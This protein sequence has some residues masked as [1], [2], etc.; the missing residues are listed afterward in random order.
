MVNAGNIVIHYSHFI[1]SQ[2]EEMTQQRILQFLGLVMIFTLLITAIGSPAA[3]SAQDVAPNPA[4]DGPTP[5][6]T[7]GTPEPSMAYPT[8]FTAYDSGWVPINP[9]QTLTLNHN[10][11]GSTDNYIVDLSFYSDNSGIEDHGI[12][13][14]MYGGNEFIAPAPSGY[15][16]GDNVGAFWHSLTTTHIKVYRMPQD[17]SYA[18]KIRVRIWVDSAED[19]DSGWH[20]ITPGGNY[21]FSFT[22]PDG[23]ADNYLVDLQ[24]RDEGTYFPPASSFGVHQRYYGG[25]SLSNND[26]VGAY[27]RTLTNSSVIV[28]LRPNETRIDSVRVRIWNNP[29]ATYDSGWQ[30]TTAGY[31]TY[32]THNI[33]GNPQDY[34]VDLEYKD[35]GT[36]GISNRCFGGC[37]LGDNDGIYSNTKEGAYWRN[38]TKSSI[39]V[40]RRADDEFAVHVRIR[41]WHFWKPSRPNFDSGWRTTTPG[42]ITNLYHGL[43]GD[44]NDYLVYFI[45]KDSTWDIHQLYF[46]SKTFGATPPGGGYAADDWAGA[47]WRALTTT[48]IIIY[49]PS[50]DLDVEQWRVYIWKMPKPDYD[51]GWTSI[52]AGTSHPFD[53]GLTGDRTDFLVDMTFKDDDT[54]VGINQRFFGGYVNSGNLYYGAHWGA[55]RTIPGDTNLTVYRYPDDFTADQVRVRIWRISIPDYES[56]YTSFTTNEVKTFSHQLKTDEHL[57]VDATAN[58]SSGDHKYFYGRVDIGTGS[59]FPTY[60]ENHRAGF[61]WYNLIGTEIM[62][63]RL[64]E[65]DHASAINLRIWRIPQ[66]IYLPLIT[67]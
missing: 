32:L 9:A 49:R 20:S 11:G 47:Y 59:P 10:L 43:G 16:A 21:T 61:Y 8:G 46:G 35:A 28:H 37:D 58:Y 57:L 56:G 53:H 44:V 25:F 18:M 39:E 31:Y 55:F 15:A 40:G 66:P 51:S 7:Q 22:I 54:V 5:V 45:Y 3:V 33:G 63:A 64:P 29:K 13:K 27:W 23:N 67:K 52:T 17:K 14:V 60:S 62:V 65:D 24:F 6:V 50:D 38:L 34:I 30:T 41:I 36:W 26:Q 12:N 4:G 48:N 2:E 1:V 42:S 19:A